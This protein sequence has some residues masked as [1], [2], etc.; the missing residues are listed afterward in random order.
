[1]A[2]AS[3]SPHK[4]P[5]AFHSAESAE[6][7]RSASDRQAC[8]DKDGQDSRGLYKSPRRCSLGSSAGVNQEPSVVVTGKSALHQSSLHSGQAESGCGP[9]VTRRPSSERVEARLLSDPNN[10]GQIW[11][12]RDGSVYLLGERTGCSVVLHEPSGFSTVGRGHLL[13]LTMGSLICLS[14]SSSDSPLNSANS[15]RG[16]DSHS[17]GSGTHKHTVVPITDSAAVGGKPWQ[18]SGYGSGP[19]TGT[20]GEARSAP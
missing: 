11:E 10:M 4:L 17:G 8:D 20:V 18:A 7:L 6:T 16:T 2:K 15:V 3:I 12:G 13:S 14:A 5:G 1:M 9:D 19:T